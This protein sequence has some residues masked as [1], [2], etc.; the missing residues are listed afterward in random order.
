MG[1]RHLDNPEIIWMLV[2]IQLM[3]PASGDGK[4][5]YGK[6]EMIVS[7]QLMSPASGD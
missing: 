3:S 6:T 5:G 7:I 2:S 1:T 4:G